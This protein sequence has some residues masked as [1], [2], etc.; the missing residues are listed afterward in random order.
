MGPDSLG[1]RGGPHFL[2]KM[3][4]YSHEK[5]FLNVAP[6]RW[7]KTSFFF[8]GNGWNPN[9]SGGGAHFTLNFWWFFTYKAFPHVALNRVGLRLFGGLWGRP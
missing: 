2:C 6:R 9:P 1:G 3:F 7:A 4:G 8:G 5:V